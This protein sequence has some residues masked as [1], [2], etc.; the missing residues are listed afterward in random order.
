MVKRQK[1]KVM[2]TKYYINRGRISL[3][4]KKEENYENNTKDNIYL[5]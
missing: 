2:A 5:D 4:N 1:I 3:S